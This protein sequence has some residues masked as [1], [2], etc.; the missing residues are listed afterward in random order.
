LRWSD[1]DPAGGT[2]AVCS[3]VLR[4]AGK[5]LFRVD[6]TK[7]AATPATSAGSGAKRATS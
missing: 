7:R 3:K 4:Q 6:E 5:G 2:V 1:F